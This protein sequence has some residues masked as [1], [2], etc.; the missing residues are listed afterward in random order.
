MEGSKFHFGVISLA[1]PVT[2]CIGEIHESGFFVRA[3]K[4][5]KDVLKTFTSLRQL[6]MYALVRTYR[7]QCIQIYFYIWYMHIAQR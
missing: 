4:G 1:Y 5:T 3:L 7:V 2:K 6:Y